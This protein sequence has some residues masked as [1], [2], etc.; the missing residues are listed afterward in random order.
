MVYLYVCFSF[1]L[2]CWLVWGVRVILSLMRTEHV[3][4]SE[5]H[6][7]PLT[8]L[9]IPFGNFFL[10]ANWTVSMNTNILL[11]KSPKP[12]FRFWHGLHTSCP[13]SIHHFPV[14]MN[15]DCLAIIVTINNTIWD[16]LILSMCVYKF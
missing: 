15:L 14:V 8:I 10:L 7:C 12:I 1:V 6:S 5:P 4:H 13:E 9:Y 2:M 11:L 3:S 16:I